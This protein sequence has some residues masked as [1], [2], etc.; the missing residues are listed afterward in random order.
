MNQ[1]ELVENVKQK[2]V[3]AF[4]KEAAKHQGFVTSED[5]LLGM[6]SAAVH[7]TMMLS[8]PKFQSLI[9]KINLSKMFQEVSAEHE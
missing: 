4:L 8:D 3:E 7:L 9:G 2:M 5:L 6:Q 1:S